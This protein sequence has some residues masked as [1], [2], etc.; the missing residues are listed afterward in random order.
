MAKPLTIGTVRLPT[1]LILAP[2]AGIT[3]LA[4]RILA[5]RQGAALCFTEMVSVEGLVREGRKSFE[6]LRR[7]EEDHPLGVQI[8]G[9]DPE[10]LARAARMVEPH[11]ELIDINMGCPVRKV[12]SNGSGSGLMR[13]PAAVGRILRA[14]RTAVD[15]PLTVKIRS[16]WACNQQTFREVARIAEEEG[17]DAITFH[18]RSRSQM[19]D[20]RADWSLL[21]ELKGLVGIPVI[22]SGDLFTAAD[23]VRMLEETGCD[24]VMLARGAMGNPWIFRETLALLEGRVIPPPTAAERGEVALQHLELFA[25]LE[26]ERVA[27]REMRKHLAWYAHGVP[28]AALFRGRV[29]NLPSRGAMEEAIGDF[30]KADGT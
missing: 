7:T 1:N 9:S 27:V 12:V 19:F 3:N 5:R 11:G 6:L 24:G 16:G 10:S 14:V 29:N 25:A 17:C 23:A 21:A 26:G 18:P 20:G 28:G 30:F 22:G 15:K 4:M 2:M 8:F 13:D